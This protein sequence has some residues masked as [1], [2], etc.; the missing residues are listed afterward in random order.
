VAG[1][2]RRHQVR[3]WLESPSLVLIAEEEAYWPRLEDQ[4]WTADRDFNR[5]DVAVRNPLI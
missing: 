3:A 1:D 2:R 4:L 5:L